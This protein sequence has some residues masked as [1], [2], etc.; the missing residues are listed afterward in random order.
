V[1]SYVTVDRYNEA[2]GYRWRITLAAYHV[3]PSSFN[4]TLGTLSGTH[5]H[6]SWITVA[7]ARTYLDGIFTLVFD[8]SETRVLH[9]KCSAVQMSAALNALPTIFD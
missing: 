6:A 4:V 8:G 3:V 1:F 9:I 7:T 2:A 5:L